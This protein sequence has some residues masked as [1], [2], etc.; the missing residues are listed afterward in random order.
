MS[1]VEMKVLHS[2]YASIVIVRAMLPLLPKTYQFI[3]NWYQI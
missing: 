2:M 1:I 3:L